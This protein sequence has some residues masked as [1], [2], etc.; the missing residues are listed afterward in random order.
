MDKHQKFLMLKMVSF[1][2]NQNRTNQS[3]IVSKAFQNVRLIRFAAETLLKLVSVP[4]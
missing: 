4:V 2:L 1:W 3:V